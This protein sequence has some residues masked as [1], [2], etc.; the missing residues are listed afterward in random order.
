M[1]LSLVLLAMI[2]AFII[3][4]ATAGQVMY[5]VISDTF[6]REDFRVIEYSS[7]LN[8][9]YL[10]NDT[11]FTYCSDV[12]LKQRVTA[13]NNSSQC[14]TVFSDLPNINSNLFVGREEDIDEIVKRVQKSNIV[15]VNGAPGFGKSSVV[16]HAGYK[17]VNNGTSVRYIDVEQKL[18][19]FKFTYFEKKPHT[20]SNKTGFHRRT[21]NRETTAIL[22]TVRSISERHNQGKT[23]MG[24]P[25]NYIKQLLLWSSEVKCFTILVLDN[26]DDLISTKFKDNFI[27]LISLL[28]GNNY[29]H[30]IVV[31]QAKLLLMNNF[32][33]WSVKELNT[34]DSVE[35]LQRLAPGISYSHAVTVSNFVEKCPLALKVVGSI[36]HLYGGDTL[37]SQLEREL[38]NNPIGVLDQVDQRKQQFR[39]IMELALSRISD[40]IS[41][42]CSHSVSLFPSSFSSEAG[43]SIL[44]QPKLCL[45]TLVKFSLLD[46][47]FYYNFVQRYRMHRLIKEFMQEKVTVSV[48]R[49]FNERFSDF[50]EDYLMHY[51]THNISHQVDEIEEYKFY[52]EMQNIHHYLSLLIQEKSRL[53]PKQLAILSLG[54][55]TE[56]ISFNALQPHFKSFIASLKEVCSLVDSDPVL[57]G[58]L[59]SHIVHHF[60]VKCMCTPSQYLKHL[61]NGDCPC[62][63]RDGVFHCQTVYDINR[64]EC[65]WVL[66]STPAQKYLERIMAY[67]CYHD[68]VFA[69]NFI[70]DIVLLTLSILRN[71]TVTNTCGMSVAMYIFV[72]ILHTIYQVRGSNMQFL[73]VMEIFLKTMCYKLLFLLLLCLSLLV[74]HTV[75]QMLLVV[76]TLI[77]LYLIMYTLWRDTTYPLQ[78]CDF[79]PLCY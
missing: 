75:R 50:Y 10:D 47:Y 59:Y 77:V 24:E 26:C 64:T 74:I 52:L 44:S 6:H 42:E 25:T 51:I 79:L 56:T 8:N 54:L 17:L 36:L 71:K 14:V 72:S 7:M 57:C 63:S 5:M 39:T 35:L 15:N 33:Q 4:I 27:D 3:I 18:P 61:M 60:Y 20:F 11:S 29:V 31:S 43:L 65:V 73:I 37:T 49:Q 1:I 28:T 9:M 41:S 12:L 40:L 69:F 30:I 2:L 46:E 38:K 70:V 67:N 68:H 66:L 21:F 78:G 19:V 55:N 58:K 22:E 53:T 13:E 76:V 48:R 62:T 32:D 45:D 34:E 16:I 23:G